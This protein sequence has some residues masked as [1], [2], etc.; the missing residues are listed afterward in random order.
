MKVKNFTALRGEDCMT[1]YVQTTGLIAANM[2]DTILQF[3]TGGVL[4]ASTCSSQTNGLG[5]QLVNHAVQITGNFASNNSWEIRNSYGTDWGEGG[6]FYLEY[7]VNACNIGETPAFYTS[8]TIKAGKSSTS[9]G[10]GGSG[11]CFSSTD[12]VTLLDGTKALISELNIGDRV[13]S[14]SGSEFTYSDVVFLPH[15]KNDIET[16]FAQVTFKTYNRVIKMTI[17]H[18]IPAGE[19]SKNAVNAEDSEFKL[20]TAGKLIPGLC[21]RT[22]AGLEE[23]AAVERVL[24]RGIYTLVTNDELVVVN[25]IVVSPFS[26]NHYVANKFYH[27]HRVLYALFPAVL[28]DKRFNIVGFFT[29]GI[30]KIAIGLIDLFSL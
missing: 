1:K 26:T 20:V 23:I 14:W 15:A 11:G 29:D 19:C 4:S 13:L 9:D 8:T 30:G 24:D 16:E 28:T 12:T 6:Y 22:M 27:I 25:G 5:G 21:V 2:N 18:L 10:G 17:E 7:G 3:Y